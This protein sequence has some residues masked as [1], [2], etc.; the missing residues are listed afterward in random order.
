[1]HSDVPRVVDTGKDALVPNDE[2]KQFLEILSPEVHVM[3]HPK[4][5]HGEFLVLPD[6][7]LEII[8]KI[9]SMVAVDLDMSEEEAEAEKSSARHP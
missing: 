4:L 7:K 3:Y 6:W 9:L 5:S 8:Q 2:A 1:M